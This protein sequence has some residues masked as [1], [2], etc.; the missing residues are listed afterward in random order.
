[1]FYPNFKQLCTAREQNEEKFK[2]HSVGI[3]QDEAEI[4]YDRLSKQ[5]CCTCEKGEK[6]PTADQLEC[7][8]CH[9]ILAVKA[10]NSK[11]K[12]RLSWNTAVLEFFCCG[13]QLCRKSVL[14]RVFL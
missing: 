11:L 4:Q 3:D 2:P 14:R 6:M 9:E 13:I 12:A 1:M 10:F 8:C 7:V 5:E